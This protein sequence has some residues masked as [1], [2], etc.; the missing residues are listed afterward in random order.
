M[1]STPTRNHS[2]HRHHHAGDTGRILQT[3]Q[4]RRKGQAAVTHCEALGW[5]LALS[6]QC[7]NGDQWTCG[8][9][10][11]PVCTAGVQHSRASSHLPAGLSIERNPEKHCLGSQ[12]GK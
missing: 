11:G 9:D 8:H 12:K 10:S 2:H 1:N 7:V 4:A 6:K 5:W 3:A